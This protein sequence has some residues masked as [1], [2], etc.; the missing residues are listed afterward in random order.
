[1]RGLERS[2]RALARDQDGA[3]LVMAALV[4][5]I[6]LFCLAGVDLLMIDATR[7]RMTIAAEA[8][9]LAAAREL[10]DEAAA[11]SAASALLDANLA[12]EPGAGDYPTATIHI[13]SWDGA[14]FEARATPATAVSVGLSRSVDAGNGL[15]LVILTVGGLHRIDVSAGAAAAYDE[16][17]CLDAGPGAAACVARLVAARD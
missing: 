3:V 7:T 9:A 16:T 4:L 1:M 6:L 15:P 11:R 12:G 2:I 14:R 8:A 5:P 17:A 10:P 13:G